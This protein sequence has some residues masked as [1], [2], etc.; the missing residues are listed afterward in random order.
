[1][2]T[3]LETQSS[4]FGG[5]LGPRKTSTE[6]WEP[7]GGLLSGHLGEGSWVVRPTPTAVRITCDRLAT[8]S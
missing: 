8:S 2:S 1:M 7:H 4:S 6:A 5:Q 3:V